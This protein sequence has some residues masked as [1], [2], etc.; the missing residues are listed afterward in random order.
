MVATLT[1]LVV[2]VLL[3]LIVIPVAKR[4]P[5]GTPTSW[6][7]GMLACTWMFGVMFL[8]YGVVP[9][10]W[11]TYAGNELNWRADKILEGPGGIIA[12]LPF[13]VTYEALKDIITVVIYVVFLGAQM[14]LTVWWQKRGKKPAAIEPTSSFG[15]PLARRA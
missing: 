1:S 2:T 14:Y 12:K 6:G 7:E 8:A 13:T 11:L 9:H 3:T 5:L 15:R 10:Q 4:R